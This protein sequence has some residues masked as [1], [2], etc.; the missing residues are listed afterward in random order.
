MQ[1][2]RP[3][4][5]STL[6]LGFSFVLLTALCGCT[7]KWYKTRADK[8]VYRI[9]QKV[10]KDIFGEAT[11]FSI[12]T[13]YKNRK[14]KEFSSEEILEERSKSEKLL[15][16]IDKALDTAI[17]FS[18][19][20][21][22][23]KEQL[24]LTAL[25]LTGER[26]SFRPQFFANSRTT[27]TRLS[28]GERRGAV[29]N[30]IGVS[31][32]LLTGADIGIGIA[33]DLLRYYT[34]DP[35]KSAASVLSVNLLQPLLRGAG[36]KIAGERLKQSHRDVFYAV[37]D[38]A[39]FQ[40]TFSTKIVILYF[41]LLQSKDTIYNEYNNYES[42]KWNVEYLRAR[43]VDRASPEEVSD[44]EQD[45]LQ[46]RNRY[47]NAIA[48]FRSSLDRFKVTL[49]LPQTT[50][51][52]LVDDE[53]TKLRSTGILPVRLTGAEGFQIALKHRLP[54][55]NEIDQFEDR[56]RQVALAADRLKADL[57]IISDAT[58][59]SDDDQPTH[60][61]EFDFDQVRANV[62]VQL[63]LPLDRLRE[64][65]DYRATLV[66]FESAIRSLG[67]TFD[68]LRNTIDQG[69]RELEQFRQNY[70]IQQGAVDL[71]ENRVAG[72]RLRLQAGTVIFR[73]L[74]ESQDALISAQ[75]AATAAL[76]DY[77]SARLNL[78][79]EL[80][81]LDTEEDGYWLDA[82]PSKV[83]LTRFGSADVPASAVDPTA[84][85][86]VVPPN[87]LFPE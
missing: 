52:R 62:G 80:G 60:Y 20:Y 77:L 14:A 4:S 15:L 39:H 17:K 29:S 30:D 32:A 28:D 85:S 44:A 7:A 55:M 34:G 49:G 45:E 31:Q 72:N 51:L 36:W 83:D 23:E 10:E 54:L 24:Y 53:M 87:Q 68:N 58:V 38:Y 11:E 59:S 67:R 25:N 63:N 81:I 56:Q 41:E 74:S 18:R 57:N 76:V 75:N 6:R 3:I 82:N 2:P 40:N 33:N 35:R 73:R 12:D 27:A 48:R 13:P 71:A 65:N 47:I 84:E 86:E 5:V 22:S 61:E 9:L 42:R 43:S 37:R 78:L 79:V 70:E 19:E 1:F 16:P 66:N 46:A 26:H 69:V 21:Q 64:R 50:D 8:Q